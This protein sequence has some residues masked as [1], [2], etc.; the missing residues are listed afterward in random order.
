MTGLWL[1]AWLAVVFVK[2]SWVISLLLLLVWGF[3]LFGLS[4]WTLEVLLVVG[5]MTDIPTQHTDFCS[6]QPR[7]FS[8]FSEK[9]ASE[10][11]KIFLANRKSSPPFALLVVE[12][13]VS[14]TGIIAV[15]GFILLWTCFTVCGF[16]KLLKP[17]ASLNC[18]F[19]G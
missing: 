9:V 10:E 2:V 14:L 4:Q 17:K 11:S 19:R 16:K 3:L 8:K 6:L 7:R 12:Q 18:D 5:V 15:L 1:R 13:C